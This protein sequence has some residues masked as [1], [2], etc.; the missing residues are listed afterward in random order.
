[1]SGPSRANRTD[2]ERAE[3]A[4][5][6]FAKLI[7]YHKMAPHTICG[8]A[9]ID[10]IHDIKPDLVSNFKFEILERNCLKLYKAEQCIAKETFSKLA[11]QISLSV[12]L[13]VHKK[14][15]DQIDQYLCLS[16]HFIDDDWKL[17]KW[18][19]KYCGVSDV[20]MDLPSEAILKSLKEYDIETKI[21]SLTAAGT[22]DLANI[23]KENV[24]ERLKLPMNGQLF[25][26][27]CSCDVI[28]CMVKKGFE[29]IDE[30]VDKVKLSGWSKS[31]PLWNLTS[32][33][34]LH[35]LR[36]FSKNGR[37]KIRKIC[38]ITERIDEI[39]E[40]LFEFRR[41]TPN[42]FLPHLQEIR[43]YL[44]HE[45]ASS[46]AFVSLVALKM[47]EILNKE[48]LRVLSV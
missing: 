46:D 45:S 36:K 29:E 42:L 17:R 35:A 22:G 43:A 26:V 16:A 21:L 13:L 7:C 30:I 24:H 34:L 14:R 12:D 38:K 44:V 20:N 25:H 6:G 2:E 47:L 1:M 15:R 32:C 48:F 27:Q 11:G 37:E 9:F 8:G 4:R 23:V 5:Q 40:A 3:D 33:N 41:P 31:L 19:I 39:T 18:V 10:L 28:S